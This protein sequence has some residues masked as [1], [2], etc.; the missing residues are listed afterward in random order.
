MKTPMLPFALSLDFTSGVLGPCNNYIRRR[1]SDMR[2]AYLDA[3]ATE[4]AIEEADPVVYE[5]YQYDVPS[6]TASCS[7]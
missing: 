3:V 2:G 4:A 1:L 5:V 6:R 7:P